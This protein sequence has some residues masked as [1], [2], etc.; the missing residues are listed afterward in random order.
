VHVSWLRQKLEQD[1]HSPSHIVTVYGL[2]Y[3]FEH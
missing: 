2:G 3:R 1:P